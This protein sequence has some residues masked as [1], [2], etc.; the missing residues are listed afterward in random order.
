MKHRTISTAMVS[1][2]LLEHGETRL[3]DMIDVLG[4]PRGTLWAILERMMEDYLVIKVRGYGFSGENT[5]YVASDVALEALE[6]MTNGF[7]FTKDTV[8]Q[9]RRS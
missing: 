3:N 8:W 1:E 7:V 5:Y 2:Y 6:G 9:C 4:Y